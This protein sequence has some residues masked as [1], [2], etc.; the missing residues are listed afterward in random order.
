VSASE[1]QDF[2]VW[3]SDERHVQTERARTA[4]AAAHQYALRRAIPFNIGLRVVAV[5]DVASFGVRL[6]RGAR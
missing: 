5:S 4:E 6:E 1:Q 2:Y 3:R